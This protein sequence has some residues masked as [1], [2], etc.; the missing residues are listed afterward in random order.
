MIIVYYPLL[1]SFNDDDSIE[2]KS[3][4]R[5]LWVVQTDFFMENENVCMNVVS[6]V[7][8]ACFL[9][10][11]LKWRILHIF[12][13]VWVSGFLLNVGKSVHYWGHAIAQLVEELCDG[14]GGRGF[15]NRSGHLNAQYS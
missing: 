14:P 5:N 7:T 2:C 6:S 8:L 11:I 9:R 1:L 4:N 13:V 3:L 15:E 12:G 10:H